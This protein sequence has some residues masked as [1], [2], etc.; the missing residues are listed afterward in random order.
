M[1]KLKRVNNLVCP[2]Q[3]VS[4]EAG[5]SGQNGDG[6]S[7]ICAAKSLHEKWLKKILVGVRIQS[8]M[9]N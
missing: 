6:D 8:N 9:I 4:F 5:S 1:L 7:V 3:F 2:L